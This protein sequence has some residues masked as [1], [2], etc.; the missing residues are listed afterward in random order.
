MGDLK[1]P[2]IALVEPSKFRNRWPI[3]Q[4]LRRH[5]SNLHLDTLAGIPFLVV[6]NHPTTQQQRQDQAS[7]PK[8]GSRCQSWNVF[9]SVLIPED[10]RCDDAH[11][12]CQ[13]YSERGENESTAF[14][15]D[16]VVI[17]DVK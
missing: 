6:P 15:G 7:R 14:V 11:K 4:S 16:V 3:S 10:I 17:P 13:W 2:K 5:I 8:S 9:G 12:I 1:I